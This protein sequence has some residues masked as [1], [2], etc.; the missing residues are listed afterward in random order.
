M[1]RQNKGKDKESGSN[2]PDE[3]SQSSQEKEK[4]PEISA[5]SHKS[6]EASSSNVTVETN[7]AKQTPTSDSVDKRKRADKVIENVLKSLN[8]DSN[9]SAM[10]AIKKKKHGTK[11]RRSPTPP[12][13]LS[14]RKKI[15]H[16]LSPSEDDDEDW[17][18]SSDSDWESDDSDD[19]SDQSEYDSDLSDA[20]KSKHGIG[21]KSSSSLH[22]AAG[23]GGGDPDPS[24][25]GAQDDGE[26]NERFRDILN[27]IPDEDEDS[28]TP[29][30]QA[31]ARLLNAIWDKSLL[32]PKKVKIYDVMDKYLRPANVDKLLLTDLNPEISRSINKKGRSRDISM[33][34][35][36]K[37]VVRAGYALGQALDKLIPLETDSVR[38]PVLDILID[39][40]TLLAHLSSKIS[41]MRRKMIKPQLDRVYQVI[42]DRVRPTQGLLFGDELQRQLTEAL[43]SSRIAYKVG[44]RSRKGRKFFYKKGKGSRRHFLQSKSLCHFID[45][46]SVQS[47]LDTS[48]MSPNTSS[49]HDE[50]CHS[51]IPKVVSNML[52][53][54]PSHTQSD[55][56]DSH[57]TH[58]PSVSNSECFDLSS[59][60]L[61]IQQQL[62]HLPDISD[63]LCCRQTS[64][65]S[66]QEPTEPPRT[67]ELDHDVP[68]VTQVGK[69]QIDF[70]QT[71]FRAGSIAYHLEYWKSL[72]SDPTILNMVRGITFDFIES[73]Q[74]RFIPAEL[75][76]NTKEQQFLDSK[77]QELLDSGVV[78]ICDHEPGEF[79]SNIFLR[80]KKDGES[81]RLI[82]DLS[83]LNDSVEYW[84]FKM[85]SLESA[86]QLI[87]PGSYMASLDIQ[88]SFFCIK[89]HPAYTKYLKFM[90]KNK[91]LQ[92]TC[93]PQ[94][95]TCSPR[96]FTKL[97]KI[98]LSYIRDKYHHLNSPFIDDIFLAGDTF[99]ETCD[100][101]AVTSEVLQSSGYPINVPKSQTFPT[102]E[103]D[104]IG[105]IISS[106]DMTVSISLDKAHSIHR[107]L[108]FMLSHRT[109]TIRKFASVVGKL[110]ATY[111][112]NKYG[113]LFT[114][115]LEQS[116]TL[117]LK[118]HSY[119]Y[120]QT[121]TISSRDKQYFRWWQKH[122]FG[123]FKP[124]LP[125]DPD[126]TVYSDSSLKGWG[127]YDPHT[128]VKHGANWPQPDTLL[129]INVL[130]L[131]AIFICL[132]SCC[133]HR[134]NSHIRVM[135]DSSVAVA[136]LNNGGS[137]KSP[138]CNEIATAI[139]FWCIRNNIWLSAAHVP[140][141][142]NVSADQASRHF[143]ED[144]EWGLDSDIFDS[145]NSLYGPCDIDLFASMYNYKLKPYVSWKP[146]PYCSHVDA[147]SIS[148]SQFSNP[149]IFGCFSLMGK[150]LQKIQLDKVKRAVIVAPHWSTQ[151][152]FPL[153]LRLTL[154][155]HV[156]KVNK[157]TLKLHHTD[158]VHP[159]A[160][161]L[162]LIV[163]LVSGQVT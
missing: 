62:Q 141:A 162:K 57:V 71:S 26:E 94:G 43:Q 93:M 41:Y 25:D 12:P 126:F 59:I 111:P 124:I 42:C 80:P 142:S 125:S 107:Q 106:L 115:P 147:F 100:N 114:K 24:R 119:D 134:Q 129:H 33:R 11:R 109:C 6:P 36:Q 7:A 16:D 151:S 152:W 88:D 117:A 27:R 75:N 121:M 163:T 21:V 158:R 144:I 45:D 65:A 77:I 156:I 79:I 127:L 130:E 131:K 47:A 64:R 13:V 20:P 148:W 2:R 34:A 155:H 56:L 29:L 51:V 35:L 91:L 74:Q 68:T 78:Q 10:P 66:R 15:R 81:F 98:P 5:E 55:S 69:Y 143:N 101:I 30:P 92:F 145:I 138:S 103:L 113:P 89:V 53:P 137:T 38:L 150:I 133:K 86:L 48:L 58:P 46:Y 54:D 154:K 61:D 97:M 132:Q 161:K 9:V 60:D 122:I 37:P 146:D 157:K 1:P 149:Y 67:A 50:T 44:G 140:G 90:H 76:F 23:A 85:D 39:V 108:Q 120:S 95:L 22:V 19:S 70:G 153:L 63:F 110:V 105:F 102:Q 14:R 104:H 159:L 4:Q 49:M 135:T 139:W 83:K 82:L 118:D 128:G 31:L 136:C 8:L 96:I 73:P 112:A 116:K 18:D 84:H 123:M 87:K 160:G 32:K 52:S 3:S 28:T 99:S 40:I 17:Q 72:T